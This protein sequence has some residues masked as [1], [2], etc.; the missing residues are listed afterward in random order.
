[1]LLETTCNA[2]VMVQNV[3]AE[4]A[5]QQAMQQQALA[6]QQQVAQVAQ[7]PPSQFAVAQQAGLNGAAP[8]LMAHH[9]VPL[10]GFELQDQLP[11]FPDV[12]HNGDLLD[13]PMFSFDPRD[14]IL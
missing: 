11:N 12:L 13:L 14:G 1:M 4:Q 7:Q 9:P 8:Q 5:M 2:Q 3:Q 6:L 10:S